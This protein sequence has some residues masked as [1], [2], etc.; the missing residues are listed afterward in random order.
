MHT[1]TLTIAPHELERGDRII[2]WLGDADEYVD[3]R[4]ARGDW[5]VDGVIVR[6]EDAPSY[7]RHRHGEVQV[8]FADA[9]INLPE[10]AEVTVER[11]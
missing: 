4:D 6:P 11:C 5:I 2:G 1:S 3:V 10:L 9:R 8:T 7:R